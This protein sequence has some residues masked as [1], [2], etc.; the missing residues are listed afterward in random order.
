MKEVSVFHTMPRRLIPRIF[1]SVLVLST[2][3]SAAMAQDASGKVLVKFRNSVSPAQALRAVQSLGGQLTGTLSGIGIH[4]VALPPFANPQAFA[5]AFN[6]RGDVEF[7]EV[8]R[9]VPPAQVTPDDPYFGS[10]WALPRIEAP[11]AWET[12]TGAPGVIIGIADT[13]VDPGHPDL[14][15]RLVAGWNFYDNNTD[16]RDV[17][18]HGTKVAGTAAAAGNNGTGVAGVCWDCWIMPLRISATNGYASYSA[19]A[20]AIVWAADHGARVVNVSYMMSTSSTVRSAA[21]Y[22]SNRG[23]V[24][25]ISAGNYSEYE[26]SPDNPYVLTVS[27]TDASDNLYSWS[28][29]GNNVDLAAP[30]CVYTTTNGG[31]YGGGCG[32]SFSAPL[33]AGV[34]ALVISE[35]PGFGGAEII[36]RLQQTADD[37]GPGGWDPT[38]GWGRVNAAGAAN[39]GGGAGGTVDTEPPSVSISSPAEGS[40][41]WGT[42][43]VEAYASDNEGVSSVNFYVDGS[44][45]RTDTSAPYSAT[46]GTDSESDGT[47]VLGV[48][49][50][51][52]AG[53][54]AYSSIAV[55]ISSAPE[56]PPPPDDTTAPTISITSPSNGQTAS[57]RVGVE[58][59]AYDAVGVVL[60]ELYVD[61]SF[62]TSS[63]SAPF[64]T[65]WNAR[66]KK[67]SNGNHTLEVRAYDAA[68]NVGSA[69]IVVT[70]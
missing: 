19:A 38:F 6:Q 58:V 7:S 68:G 23:G 66:P 15:S 40:T 70:K 11:A 64:T 24:V 52:A 4:V 44:L 8:D 25:S 62:E 55:E 33:V 48:M 27:A 53:N 22:M 13:G 34:A 46:W 31:G 12:T 43:L 26:T 18:G 57:G 45:L 10:Q 28:N 14:S 37:K 69:S 20:S 51:D 54:S 56:P 1:L 16:T 5:N 61:G 65:S 47:H 21:Q 2:I 35:N 32:T 59:A 50:L 60:V 3:A 42:V 67:V 9:V 36:E 17:Y 29:T 49:A 63:S 39:P 41:V 30:G